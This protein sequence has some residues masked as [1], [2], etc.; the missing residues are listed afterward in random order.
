MKIEVVVYSLY[1]YR[2]QSKKKPAKHNGLYVPKD[3]FEKARSYYYARIELAKQKWSRKLVK[4]YPGM[5]F[6]DKTE[7]RRFC[8]SHSLAS[9]QA[10]VKFTIHKYVLDH[11]TSFEHLCR[12]E[13]SKEAIDEAHQKA[14]RIMS[15]WRGRDAGM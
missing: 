5:P 3:T 1:Q 7:L 4:T 2:P 14:K 12:E 15:I 9:K 13:S 8:F 6:T 10:E 11:Y